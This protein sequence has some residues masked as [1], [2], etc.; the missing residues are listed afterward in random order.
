MRAPRPGGDTE[1]SQQ[2]FK[3]APKQAD[4][5]ANKGEKVMTDV[6]V[7]SRFSSDGQDRTSTAGQV[8]NCEAIAAREG[9]RVVKKFAD[10]GRPGY[11]DHR[12]EY[13]RMLSELKRGSVG[14]ILC[15]ETSRLSRSQAELHRL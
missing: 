13:Q 2:A 11:D 6:F 15:D 1:G 3:P 14:G 10:E 12:P 9:L 5:D 7:Y 4:Q 8:A